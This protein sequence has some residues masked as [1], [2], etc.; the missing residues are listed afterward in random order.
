[1]SMG[2]RKRTYINTTTARQCTRGDEMVSSI[3]GMPDLKD[4][5]DYLG[6]GIWPDSY[7]AS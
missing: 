2:T 5:C 1:M 4:T 3:E 7:D 6:V